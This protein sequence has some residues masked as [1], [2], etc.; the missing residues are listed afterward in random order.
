MEALSYTMASLESP[1]AVVPVLEA[2]GRRHLT[3]GAR[4]E[5]YDTVV[6]A[7]LL[8]MRDVLEARFTTEVEKAWRKAL[9]WVAEIMKQ[10]AEP[11]KR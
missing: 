5:H 8:A 6:E 4:V 2:L 7:L 3:Y 11:I 1:Q 9:V 10:G